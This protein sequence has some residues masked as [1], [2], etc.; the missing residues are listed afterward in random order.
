MHKHIV[1]GVLC[2]RLDDDHI[3]KTLVVFCTI[4]LYIFK[5]IYVYIYIIV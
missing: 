2:D 3:T 4:L 1:V 5:N